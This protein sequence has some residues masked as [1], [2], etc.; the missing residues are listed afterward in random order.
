MNKDMSPEERLLH[1][2]KEN[3]QE[4]APKKEEKE[5]EPDISVDLPK[6]PQKI[7]EISKPSLDAPKKEEPKEPVAEKKVSKAPSLSLNIT[8]IYIVIA[9][10]LL[11]GIGYFGY[12]LFANK[13][14]EELKN[15]QKLIDSISS[16]T[17][18]SKESK[19]KEPKKEK[20][21]QPAQSSFDDYQKLLSEKTIFAPPVS[22]RDKKQTQEGPG[23][24]EL[25]KEL[26]LVGIMPGDEPQAIIED[27]K[28]G[29]TLFLKKGES[30][31]NI[32]IK[33]IESGRVL[34]GYGEDTITLSL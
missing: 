4:P 23:L 26:T 30:I 18:E 24:R 5:K 21:E 27:K 19:E 1:L 16:E 20:A 25:V 9:I 15:L 6:E 10:I 31:D 11:I 32:E 22:R 7:K 28:S 34:L 17:E 33:D 29:Q 3:K 14:D 2:I 12:N 13:E 8:H